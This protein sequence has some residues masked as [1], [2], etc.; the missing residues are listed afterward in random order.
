M[1]ELREILFASLRTSAMDEVDS[2]VIH[3]DPALEERRSMLAAEHA[4]NAALA[5]G[6]TVLD[7]LRTPGVAP[8]EE[9]GDPAEGADEYVGHPE[10][11]AALRSMALYGLAGRYSLLGIEGGRALLS[12]FHRRCDAAGLPAAT[13]A[14]GEVLSFPEMR[15]IMLEGML[16]G[17]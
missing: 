13:A 1:G 2:G 17:G 15:E 5:A 14:M 16:V 12:E 11:D 3:F 8:D 7:V 4:L 6:Y 9:E 10:L